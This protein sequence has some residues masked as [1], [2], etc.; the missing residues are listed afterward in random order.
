MKWIR[1]SSSF[2]STERIA[3]AILSEG[4][5]EAYGRFWLLVELISANMERDISEPV[6]SYP[7]KELSNKLRTNR[8]GLEKFLEMLLGLRAIELECHQELIDTF[9]ETLQEHC[10]NLG[11]TSKNAPVAI[12]SEVRISCDYIREIAD[13]NAITSDKRKKSGAPRVEENRVNYSKGDYNQIK[14]YQDEIKSDHSKTR[15]KIDKSRSEIPTF[16]EDDIPF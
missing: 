7:L 11:P 4:G 9:P 2:S 5:I 8:K 14:S 3:A 1:H 15:S 10:R 16:S 6:I 12:K 13:R